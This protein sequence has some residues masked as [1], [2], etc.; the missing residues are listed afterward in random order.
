MRYFAYS[1]SVGASSGNK[2]R[3]SGIALSLSIIVDV[4]SGTEL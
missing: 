4:F 1:A 3:L 2:M